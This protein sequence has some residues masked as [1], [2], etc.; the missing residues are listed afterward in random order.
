M[1]GYKVGLN[2]TVSTY[3]F[4]AHSGA[5]TELQVI[6]SLPADCAERSTGAEIA[7]APSGQFVYASNRGHDSIVIFAVDPNSGRLKTI[8][9]E[10]TQGRQPRHFALDPSGRF[11]YAANQASDCITTF[12]VDRTSG[13]L[14]ATGQVVRTGSPVSIV[15]GRE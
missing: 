14:A 15:F 5:L 3:Q 10:P 2:S 7:V 1:D 6:T 8:G 4:H 12:A 11:L 9:W 13:T